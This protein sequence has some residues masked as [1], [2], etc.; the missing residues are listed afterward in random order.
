MWNFN[1]LLGIS[2]YEIINFRQDKKCI[3]VQLKPRRKTANCS[4][5][6]KPTHTVKACGKERSVLHGTIIGKIVYLFFKR[7]RFFCNSCGKIFSEDH[8]VLKIRSR[9][10]QIHKKEVVFNLSDRSFASGSK[11]FNVS[12]HTQRRW[13]KELIEQ[14]VLNFTEEK[15]D[16]TP[17][18]LGIDEVSFAGREMVTTIGNITRKKL[19]GVLRSRRKDEL[20]KCLKSI[21]PKVKPLIKEVVIDMCELYR[22]AV[23][24]S[25]PQASIVVD[26]FHVIQDANKRIDQQ[27]LILQEI[28]GKKIPRYILTK[29]REDL[30]GQQIHY[31]AEI[32][33]KYPELEMYYRIKERIR[34]MYKAK[35]KEEA[36]DQIR[37]IILSLKSSDDGSLFLWGNTL[38]RWKLNILNYFDN[39]STNGY[40]EGMHNKMKLIKRISFGFRNK[41]V[42]IHKVMLSVLISVLFLPH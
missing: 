1:K 9:A 21:S 15:Q 25:L 31:L 27:R 16:N 19:K 39:R 18:V 20:K 23:K 28:Y 11:R 12:Y 34:D 26:H 42:F 40:M 30:K 38:S 8:P 10:T 37:T 35:T 5:C 7:R 13:L 14:E 6:G 22:R 4:S 32:I 36:E 24:E 33:K 41:E 29:N 3:F 17:F 2:S